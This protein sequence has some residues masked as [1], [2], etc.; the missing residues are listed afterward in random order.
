MGKRGPA[1][2]PT[3]LKILAGN[4]GKR[5]LPTAEPQPKSGA[6]AMPKWL[7]KAGK[8]EWRKVVAELRRL[9][10]IT[11]IDGA[12]LAAYCAAVA[13]L[14]A[15]TES[16]NA[17]G[18]I[19]TVPVHNRDGEPVGEK[20]V[21]NPAVKMQRDASMVI[22]SFLAEFGLSPSGR[23]RL[24]APKAAEQDEFEAFLATPAG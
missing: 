10:L 3:K 15:A 21:V 18:R 9:G 13:E 24:V 22:K 17:E 6:P 8:A 4:P 16:I 7:P 12:A 19:I 5:R 2:T 20:R 1:P 14:Q 23:V 11:V